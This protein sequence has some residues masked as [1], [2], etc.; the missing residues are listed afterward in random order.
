V[1]PSRSAEQVTSGRLA[2][3]TLA[4]LALAPAAVALVAAELWLAPP[5]GDI[6]YPTSHTR[7]FPVF[8]CSVG[9]AGA[10]ATACGASEHTEGAR[11][12][13]AVAAPFVLA[14]FV[15]SAGR[16]ARRGGGP[17]GGARAASSDGSPASLVL[18]AVISIQLALLAFA[19]WAWVKQ[20]DAP[21]R[22]P[23]SDGDSIYF[24]L[25]DIAAAVLIA[26]G[27]LFLVLTRRNSL[28]RRWSRLGV[29]G[30]GGWLVAAAVILTG[31]WLLPAVFFD[32]NLGFAHYIPRAHTAA[33]FEEYLA[34]LNH[35]T[36]LADFASAY[37]SLLPF[38]MAPVFSIIGTSIGDFTTVMTLISA[39][40]L[41]A[42]FGTLALLTGS[43]ARAFGLYIPFLAI[44]LFPAIERRD[45]VYFAANHYALFPNRYL[46][47]WVVAA[48]CAL[49]LA[50]GRPRNPAWLFLA[51]GLVVLNNVEFGLPCLGA[52]LVAVWLGGETS[53]GSRSQ[54]RTIA[55]QAGLGL[56]G[57]LA[58]VCLIVLVRVSELPDFGL[59]WYWARLFAVAGFGLLP[60]PTLGYHTLVYLTFAATLVTAAVRRATGSGD[61]AL[62]AMLAY[63]GVFGLGAGAYYAGRSAP[64][65]LVGL[66]SAWGFS[67]ALLTMAAIRSLSVAR[68]T[69]RRALLGSLVPCLAVLT[70]FG[71]MVS[72]I[73]HFPWTPTQVER[74]SR[75]AGEVADVSATVNFVDRR[76]GEGERV[77]I[78][79]ALGHEVGRRSETINTFPYHHQL[80]IFSVE[81]MDF[82]MDTLL[83]EG[84]TKLFVSYEIVDDVPN[85]LR[86]HGFR[87]V[88]R[89]RASGL[90]EWSAPWAPPPRSS[91]AR[92]DVSGA[93]ASARS[94]GSD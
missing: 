69:G 71:V 90:T 46:G 7:L 29:H 70:G 24:S 60:M 38:P 16:R 35:R 59:L 82:A 63:S 67:I 41:L 89:D 17:L 45:Q 13:L 42:I 37:A 85:Y 2:P 58:L 75:T 52:T 25:G 14:G 32:G 53:S 66:F 79:S 93:S 94:R 91:A 74:L 77:S 81:Q 33:S 21:T 80:S 92:G 28:E 64:V 51:A 62:T 19:A 65:V 83:G 55:G 15:L 23:R 26:S 18:P 72:A 50:R 76:S 84:G 10:T 56:A 1:P 68:K 54:L 43:K 49:H 48:L 11:Y 27:V 78:L 44:S 3:A 36:P 31:L 20:K 22:L 30:A 88:G 5:L 73:R 47:P 40:S 86:A 4:W 39:A 87:R 8:Q 6:L 61:R 34:V 12:L 57:A 9:G